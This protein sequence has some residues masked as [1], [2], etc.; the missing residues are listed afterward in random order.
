MKN[1]NKAPIDVVSAVAAL[2]LSPKAFENTDAKEAR[3]IEAISD[4][5]EDFYGAGIYDLVNA[6]ARTESIQ[7]L[8][9]SHTSKGGDAIAS[10]D[11]KDWQYASEGEDFAGPDGNKDTYSCEFRVGTLGQ[12]YFN[13]YPKSLQGTDADLQGLAGVLD[14]SNGKPRLLCGIDEHEMLLAIN[15]DVHTGVFLQKENHH[16][17]SSSALAPDTRMP[18]IHY[19]GGTDPEWIDRTR[20]VIAEKLFQNHNFSGCSI[21]RQGKWNVDDNVYKLRLMQTKPFDVDSDHQEREVNFFVEFALD[22]PE[23]LVVVNCFV[24]PE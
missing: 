20:E 8:I 1:T 19:T 16:V 4:V 17:L 18:A 6:G 21:D 9:D 15:S 13:I 24:Q 10:F 5:I 12:L 7:A 14:I 2:L 22:A 3:F 11:M 23:S